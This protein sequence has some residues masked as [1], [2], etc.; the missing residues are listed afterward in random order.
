MS[1]VAAPGFLPADYVP[2][3]CPVDS[4]TVIAVGD[5]LWLNTDDVRPATAQADQGT[6]S[7]SQAAFHGNFAGIAM[8]ASGNGESDPIQVATGGVWDCTCPSASFDIG[9][10]I[11][12]T[13]AGSGDTLQDQQV[14]GVS[15]VSE[16][17]G[18]CVLTAA[19]TT[20]VRVE[21][22]SS[23]FRGGAQPIA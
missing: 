12:P 17:I 9:D 13:E 16:A 7:L 11:G 23:V 14:A 4:A 22:V 15:S 1:I 6:E 5:L 21:F 10:L 2:V 20:T 8:E 19:S 18:R 3:L